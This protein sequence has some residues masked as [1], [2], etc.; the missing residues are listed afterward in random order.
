MSLAP[1][2]VLLT[3]VSPS[4]PPSVTCLRVLGRRVCIC[5]AQLHSFLGLDYSRL[6][7]KSA[8][9]GLKISSHTGYHMPEGLLDTPKH[10]G[11]EQQKRS[12]KGP[13]SLP[14]AMA[15]KAPLPMFLFIDRSQVILAYMGQGDGQRRQT[16]RRLR[17]RS[18]HVANAM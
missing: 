5:P 12:S 18:K 11:R 15:H 3:L 2:L 7:L 10:R 8:L 6:P 16:T 14:S 9:I 13:D 4:P 1:C 17:T